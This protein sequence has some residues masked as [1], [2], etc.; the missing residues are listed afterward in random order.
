MKKITLLALALIC[1][2]V[3]M[4]QSVM[5]KSVG[6]PVTAPESGKLYAIECNSQQ[7]YTT[8]MYDAG[9]SPKGTQN[10]VN[11]GDVAEIKYFWTITP[12][13][14][15]GVYTF[16]NYATKNYISITGTGNGGS[17]VMSSSEAQTIITVGES[18]GYVALK[19]M[20]ADQW[21]DMGWTGEGISTWSGGVAGSRRMQIREITIEE[22]SDLEVAL[23]NLKSVGSDYVVNHPV[24]DAKSMIGTTPGCYGEAAVNA[25]DEA[26][27]YATSILDE[28]GG[29][30][31][32]EEIRAAAQAI[33]DTWAAVEASR[34]PYAQTI[35]PGY[36]VIKNAMDFTTTTTTPE[37]EDPE[38]GE[39]IPGQTTTEHTPKAIYDNKGTASWKTF[40]KK[41]DFLF[42]VSATNTDKQ[43]K[44]VN[45]LNGNSFNEVTT[46]SDLAMSVNENPI[47]FDWRATDYPVYTGNGDEI[48]N[49]MVYNIRLASQ[50]E[51]S[52]KYLHAGGHGG[53]AGK[54]GTIVGWS[55]NTPDEEGE[56]ICASDWYLE[57]I[58]EAVALAWIEDASP[59]KKITAMIDE[60]NAIKNALPAQKEI[61][62][63]R[64]LKPLITS[65]SQ[66]SSPYTSSVEGSIN[67]LIDGDKSTY[68]HSDWSTEP[69]A[70]VHYLQ[71]NIAEE[72]IANVLVRMS[73]RQG[74][75]NDHPT[76][77]HA[78]GY[79][80]DSE[81]LTFAE[82]QDLGVLE[83][84]FAA[85]GETVEA[86]LPT[87][88][89]K[90]YIR[91]Y[92]E[93]S[94]G[95]A[96]RG[97]WHASEFQLYIDNG[98]VA[99]T[100]QAVARASEIA[101]LEAALAA[102]N[103]GN[104]TATTVTDPQDA[105]F[106]AAYNAVIN[107]N[108]AWMAV[109]VDPAELRAAI[110]SAE[111]VT[112]N[113]AVGTDPGYWSAG[114]NAANAKTAVDAALA[115]SNSG[116]YTPAGIEAQLKTLEAASGEIQDAANQPVEGKWYSIKF[117]T[118]A[119][120]DANGWN[121]DNVTNETLGNLYDC[122]AAPA[123]V[124]TEEE[125]SEFEVAEEVT[126]GQEVRFVSENDLNRDEDMAF[127]FVSVGDN[128]YTIQ[129]KSGLYLSQNCQLSLAPA[130]FKV[131]AIGK[132]KVLIN[133][134]DM[135]GEA[136]QK[137]DAPANLHA[138][139]AGH[140][141]VTWSSTDL[142]SNSAL[143]IHEINVKGEADAAL[144]AV[145]PNGMKIMCYPLSYSVS[146]G[147]LYELAGRKVEGDEQ[148]LCFNKIDMTTPGKAVLYVNGNPEEE[149]DEEEGTENVSLTTNASKLSAPVAYNGM[150]GSYEYA[151]PSDEG[152]SQVVVVARE[153]YATR[154]G[155]AL[156]TMAS[157]D[158]DGQHVYD[159][160]GNE[161]RD[162]T[163][164][165]GWIELN[166]TPIVTG[167]YDLEITI[168]G[169][170][171]AIKDIVADLQKNGKIYTI[172]GKFVGN[173][174]LNNIKSMPKGVYIVNGVKIA[175]K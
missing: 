111:Q 85:A 109:Y 125:T 82:G 164:Y 48:K 148:T 156:A 90:P 12:S 22:V 94:N 24:E 34:V 105:T 118:E 108:N 144:M 38:T 173:G 98:T 10:A 45:M 102:W 116:A 56:Q 79:D 62:E 1:S 121:K 78:M 153:Y 35:K 2:V 9:S 66:F 120:Y 163:A 95:S 124:V 112:K 18:D 92:W 29:G 23:A 25:Y 142:S 143:Y 73:R 128:N 75:V 5:V 140:L 161:G 117:D 131:N 146:D 106:L 113:I 8:W 170:L 145:N 55:T 93:E 49:V 162:I 36:Y 43:Y 126:A 132:G 107:A 76:K 72:E 165:T 67:N 152:T 127:R 15:E 99:T 97:Y 96:Q 3:G 87:T 52:N 137:N 21:I 53:G 104:F 58:D 155:Y 59:V 64:A 88:G 60:V 27:D 168:N 110:S 89:G 16:Q 68:W 81:D 26:I 141:L 171:T 4:A 57:E 135:E 172:D 150:H 20:T 160:N 74:A 80:S 123:S 77:L 130:I 166:E 115:Y 91:F 84:P 86:T 39:T 114:S 103:E 134:Y 169:N 154:F 6:E 46:S 101:A 151:W 63:D 61:A 50:A 136:V 83:F 157:T 122:V 71:V 13:S 149:K 100:T 147:D 37:T 138:Q 167:S 7:N 14:A 40:E 11:A 119:N 44:V 31:S 33:I 28:Q 139:N 51:R 54:Y 129:H 30:L 65:N 32:E 133:M 158:K 47:V 19:H 70:D 159:K 42:K 41:A 174:S 175:V 17:V 69:E